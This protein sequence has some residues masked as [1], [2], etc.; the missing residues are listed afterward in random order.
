MKVFWFFFSKKNRFLLL[1]GGPD[2]P[3]VSFKVTLRGASP[4]PFW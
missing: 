1:K 3:P 4:C 2:G